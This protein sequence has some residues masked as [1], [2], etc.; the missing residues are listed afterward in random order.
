VQTQVEELADNRVRLT[1]GVPGAD[2]KHAV[3]HAT[4]DLVASTKIPGFRRGKVPRQVLI[5]RIGRDRIY[6]EAVESHISG[7]FWKAADATRVRPVEQPAY[8]YDLPASDEGDWQFTA[9]VSVQPK[10]EPPDWTKLEVPAL[11]P[12]V[13]PEAVDAEIEAIRSAVAELAPVEGRPAREGDT[14]VVDVVESTGATQRDL[15]VEL[16]AG[17]LLEEIERGLVGASAGETRSIEVELADGSRQQIDVTLKEIKEKV[18]P[19]VD[20][21]LARAAT[22]FDTLAELRSEIEGR[23]REQL[24]VETESAFRAAVADALVD[25][26]NV[27]PS[28][29]L[30]EARAAD[31]W[32]GLVRSLAGRGVDPNTYFQLT[33]QGPDEVQARLRAEA[34]RSVAREL[35]LEAIAD[36]LEI[37][38]SDDELKEFLRG[39]TRP[40]E[41]TEELIEQVWGTGRQETLREDL[42]LRRALDRAAAE[43]TRIP[44]DLAAAREKLWTPEKERATTDTTL[45]TPGSKEPA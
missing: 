38:V 33:G 11:E 17:R 16:G 37:E 4:A 32:R 1:V 35:V 20:D 43:V 22:E 23:L 39:E 44:A 5:S 7:W 24:E 3:E 30:V 21:E 9:T 42:R 28:G 13:P 6:G 29:A 2:V 40:G 41:D 15:V 19:P 10:P 12:D 8:D 18:L 31:L 26:A 14:V 45:W 25:A 34:E 27:S 36:K